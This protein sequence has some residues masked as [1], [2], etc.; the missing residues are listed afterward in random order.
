[1]MYFKYLYII[2]KYTIINYINDSGDANFFFSIGPNMTYK[3]CKITVLLTQYN[4]L[5]TIYIVNFSSSVLSI[6]IRLKFVS[7][8]FMSP[9]LIIIYVSII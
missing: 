4:L 6:H 3:T 8:H 5:K 9:L 7:S 1:M 2:N